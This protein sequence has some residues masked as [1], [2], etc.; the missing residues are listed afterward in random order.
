M[1]IHKV[2]EFFEFPCS[3]SSLPSGKRML[4]HRSPPE[5]VSAGKL[6]FSRVRSSVYERFAEPCVDKT[7]G[8]MQFQN[9]F[10][11]LHCGT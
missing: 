9:E 4:S 3:G 10:S 6:T 5:C 1:H 8:L 2:S 7:L 11:A